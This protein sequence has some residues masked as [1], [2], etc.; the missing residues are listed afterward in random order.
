MRRR[1]GREERSETLWHLP[2][3][4]DSKSDHILLRKRERGR[5]GRRQTTKHTFFFFNVLHQLE[6]MKH[7]APSSETLS[8]E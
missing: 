8:D 4:G 7:K 1:R 3:F 5:R 6:L 2:K